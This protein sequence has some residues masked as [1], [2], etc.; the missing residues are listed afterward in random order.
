MNG[1]PMLDQLAR[2]AK[3]SRRVPAGATCADCGGTDQ[4]SASTDGVVRC[5]EH[6]PTTAAAERD[7]PAGR[8][9]IGGFTIALTPA[10]HR[11]VSDLRIA[12]GIDRWPPPQGNPLVAVGHA[13]AGFASLLWLIAKYLIET[14]VWFGRH[15]GPTGWERAP[16]SPFVI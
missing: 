16:R 1:D 4:L 14:G 15:L 7:H 11:E 3:R 13:V 9:N 12:L 10:A 5:Y 6:K 2:Q 8:H